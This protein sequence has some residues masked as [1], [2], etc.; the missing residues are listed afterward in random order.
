[1]KRILNIIVYLCVLLQLGQLQGQQVI[2]TFLIKDL[3]GEGMKA[4]P[5]YHLHEGAGYY[6]YVVEKDMFDADWDVVDGEVIIRNADQKEFRYEVKGEVIE[7]YTLPSKIDTVAGGCL[8]ILKFTKDFKLVDYAIIKNVRNITPIT[9]NELKIS[10]DKI[11]LSKWIHLSYPV[12]VYDREFPTGIETNT[13][14]TM[15]S[16]IVLDE[17]MEAESVGYFPQAGLKDYVVNGDSEVILACQL[18]DNIQNEFVIAGD[19][20]KNNL[21][22]SSGFSNENVVLCNYDHTADTLVWWKL[23]SNDLGVQVEEM[24]EGPGDKL[25]IHLTAASPYVYVGPEDAA[26]DSVAVFGTAVDWLP[27]KRDHLVMIFDKSGEY[28]S[29]IT[30]PEGVFDNWYSFEVDADGSVYV[31]AAYYRDTLRVRDTVFRNEYAI[32]NPSES[33]F[34]S[35]ILKFTPEGE[36]DWGFYPE[37]DYNKYSIYEVRVQKDWIYVMGILYGEYIQIGDSTVYRGEENF[38]KHP[39]FRISKDGT[40]K[41]L[42]FNPDNSYDAIIDLR[43]INNDTLVIVPGLGVDNWLY[44]YQWKL[45]SSIGLLKVDFSEKTVSNNRTVLKEFP[46]AKIYP[47]PAHAGSN[48]RLEFK[49]NVNVKSVVIYDG[50]G[51]PVADTDHV[52]IQTMKVKIPEVPPGQYYI[53]CTLEDGIFFKPLV[54]Q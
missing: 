20:I 13:Y 23:I 34:R 32:R 50:N 43:E 5:Y 36:F 37:G 45:H 12:M 19:T 21:F 51:R 52:A 26:T 47:N 40:K 22:S 30:I 38:A 11:L 16:L 35:G 31:S 41:E 25:Y 28:Q 42:L 49:D 4:E 27:Q 1:M 44:N 10:E 33:S 18:P 2:D 9:N 24:V 15:N 53:K 7:G 14:E 54:V 46:G 39:L 48:L 3:T 8:L 29:S 17:E 6:Y